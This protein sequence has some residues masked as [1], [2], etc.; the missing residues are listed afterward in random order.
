MRF[1]LLSAFAL[2][3][4]FV[5][6]PAAAQQ[7]LSS[8]ITTAVT[9]V[10]GTTYQFRGSVPDRLSLQAVFTYGSG[11]TNATAYVQ[12][13]FDNATWVDVASF[14]FT[15]ASATK[16]VNVSALTPVTTVYTPTDGSLSANTVK[17]GLIG[18]RVRVKLTTTGT[19][20]GGTTLVVTAIGPNSLNP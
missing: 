13:T 12:T 10:A 2:G 8:T 16:V 19:Y 11:G 9:G 6:G 14:Q 17:D 4:G 5:S 20:A 7:V 3:V 15:T 1:R 18:K